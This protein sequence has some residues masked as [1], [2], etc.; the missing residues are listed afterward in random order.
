MSG[1]YPVEMTPFLGPG[2]DETGP[3]WTCERDRSRVLH[4]VEPARLK[5]RDAG[6]P[7]QLSERQWRRLPQRLRQQGDCQRRMDCVG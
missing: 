7:L 3:S 5:R 4:K 6:A 1:L 2:G